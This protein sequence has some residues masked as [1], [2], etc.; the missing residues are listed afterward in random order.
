MA[1]QERDAQKRHALECLGWR[2]IE[3]WECETRDPETLRS[4]LLRHFPDH[5]H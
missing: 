4:V 1:N 5:K 2:V 3:V